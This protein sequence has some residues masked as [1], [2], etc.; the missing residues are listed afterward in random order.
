MEVGESGAQSHPLL[1]IKFEAS[2]SFMKPFSKKKKHSQQILSQEKASENGNF[3]QAFL[4]PSLP[5]YTLE[6]S[7]DSE[8]VNLARVGSSATCSRDLGGACKQQGL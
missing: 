6:V 7:A 2:L 5:M 4:C 1:Y 3:L 8:P